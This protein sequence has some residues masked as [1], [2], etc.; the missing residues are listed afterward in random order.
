MEL[1]GKGIRNIMMLTNL[2]I[3]VLRFL[4]STFVFPSD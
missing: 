1:L 3:F 2:Y 4:I